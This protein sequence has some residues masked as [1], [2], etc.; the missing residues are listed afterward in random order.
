MQLDRYDSLT[1][2]THHTEAWLSGRAD[3]IIA[4]ARSVQA[5]AVRRGMPADRITVVPNG[6]DTEVMR[7]DPT[8]GRARRRMWGLSDDAFVIG[9]VARLDPMK[10]H[11]NLL[12]AVASFGR[13][14]PNMRMV[15]VGTGAAH[16]RKQL[17]QTA[18][19]LGVADRVVWAGETRDVR[20]AYAAFDIATLPSA[21]GE[22]FSNVIGEAMACG[23]P[24]VATDI[25]DARA[26][27]GGN[28]EVVAPSDPAALC[29]GWARLR[30][31]LD[32]ALRA[33][34]RD[35][36]IATYGL[37]VMTDRTEMILSGLISTAPAKMR[38]R[39]LL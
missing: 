25:G 9:C 35:S 23:T 20:A 5:D 22:G 2:F 17:E 30:Q 10:D 31:R 29:A 1:A 13:D 39:E 14:A 8:A 15:C 36:I 12:R 24:V 28:G 26:I 34:A 4:N 16:Y 21:F 38:A 18:V 33:A 3:L 37:E 7:P 6:I 32:P 19:S 11:S 27:I